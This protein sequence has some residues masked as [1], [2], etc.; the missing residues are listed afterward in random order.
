MK[1]WLQQ[2][3][4]KIG[5]L[6]FIVGVWVMVLLTMGV[7]ASVADVTKLTPSNAAVLIG[8]FGLL[9]TALPFTVGKRKDDDRDDS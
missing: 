5:L 6:R 4:E 1:K 7:S 9:A 3:I 2:Q 8:I